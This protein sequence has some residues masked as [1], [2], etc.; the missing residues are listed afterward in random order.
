MEEERDLSNA[1]RTT[2]LAPA[3]QGQGLNDL[4]IRFFRMAERRIVEK[5][6]EGIVSFIS[7]YSWLDG[8]SFTGMRERYLEVFDS[9]TVDCLNGDKYKTGKLTPEGKPDPSVFSTEAN[10]EGI[11]VGTAIAT[12]IRRSR[13]EEAQTSKKK[14]QRLTSSPTGEVH[15]RHLWGKDKREELLAT[16]NEPPKKVYTKIKPLLEVGLPFLPIKTE[17]CYYQWPLLTNLFPVSFPGVKTSRDKFLVD[18]EKDALLERIEKYFDPQISHAEMKRLDLG[19][20]DDS[21]RFQAELVREELR[22]RGCLKN[23]VVRYCYR[24]FDVRWLYWEPETK[25]L[26]EKRAEYFPQVFDGNVYL[27]TQQKPRRKWS[28]PQFI[29]SIGCID[30]MDRSATCFPLWL[31]EE[32]NLSVSALRETPDL[33]SPRSD[34]GGGRPKSTTKPNLSAAAAAYTAGLMAKPE[35]LFYHTLAVLHSPAY[36]KENSG[37]LR[38]D[39]P[40]VALPKS[41][42]VLLAS[43]ELGEQVAALLDSETQ[44]TGVAN[45]SVRPELKTIAVLSSTRDLSLTAGWGHAGQNG[46]TMPGKGK[47]ET[48]AFAAE[49]A[50]AFGA[51]VV[52]TRGAPASE[53]DSESSNASLPGD[54]LRVGTTRAPSDLLGPATHDVYLNE[55]ACW[56]NVPAA[57]WDYTIGGYQVIKKWLSYREHDLLGRPL[58]PDEAREVT[59]MARRIAALILLQPALD[60]NYEAVKSAAVPLH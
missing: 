3:P 22:R 29:R 40:R 45:G 60:R 16:L 1:Y 10:R 36:R 15:F 35:T 56:C 17:S 14:S 47:L 6:G 28:E 12:L 23:N 55:S 51:R 2:K 52:P 48:R 9:I 31:R 58:T 26:D 24:P 18:V 44:L 7:N 37:A 59:H 46:V 49:E 33:F 13:R 4:Y 30:L 39:W 41:C 34:G 5:S 25:L 32:V 54:A 11:Q 43:A 38:Q 57:V 19:V 50:A 27:V 53:G 20:M 21:A 8:L 42:E